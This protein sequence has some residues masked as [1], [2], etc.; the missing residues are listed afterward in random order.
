MDSFGILGPSPENPLQNL[1]RA[2]HDGDQET[3]ATILSQNLVNLEQTDENGLTPLMCASL[4]DHK[5]CLSLLLEV[6]NIDVNYTNTRR[7]TAL[8]IAIEHCS[9][10]CAKELINNPRVDVNAPHPGI[11]DQFLP[12]TPLIQAVLNGDKLMVS[13]LMASTQLDVNRLFGPDN[14]RKSALLCACSSP[15]FMSEIL[16][17][18]ITHEGIDLNQRDSRGNTPLLLLLLNGSGSYSRTRDV[19]KQLLEDPR[20]RI[21]DENA[22][23]LTALETVV[24]DGNIQ[25]ARLLLEHGADPLLIKRDFEVLGHRMRELLYEYTSRPPVL[26]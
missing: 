6:P 16:K 26:K 17:T 4:H 25:M 20:L 5:N 8:T 24:C 19:V 14:D 2:C 23:G 15:F 13:L 11:T 12:R 7:Q 22:H 1:L 10:T 3:V 18:L 21:D 9:Y